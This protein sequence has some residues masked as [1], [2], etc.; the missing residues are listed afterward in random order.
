MRRWVGVGSK[1]F[2]LVKGWE[3]DCFD[4][5]D[6]GW[7]WNM[8]LELA[9]KRGKSLKSHVDILTNKADSSIKT[10][11]YKISH[12]RALN[13]QYLPLLHI[14]S[15]KTTNKNLLLTHYYKKTPI[16]SLTHQSNPRHK[17]H[18]HHSPLPPSVYT[19]NVYNSR[20]F[21]STLP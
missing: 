1:L 18:K 2:V 10:L 16:Y 12:T 20:I 8:Y 11:R 3:G 6:G 19:S 5:R 21:F 15:S 13:N 4:R 9:W 17:N 7:V 14:K